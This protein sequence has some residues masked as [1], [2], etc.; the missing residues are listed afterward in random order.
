MRILHTSIV[1]ALLQTLFGVLIVLMVSSELFYGL[2]YHWEC[3]YMYV[4]CIVVHVA[5]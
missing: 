4:H 2:S 3:A 1:Y 5:S